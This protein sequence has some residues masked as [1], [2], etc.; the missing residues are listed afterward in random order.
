MVGAV[1]GGGGGPAAQLWVKN[2]LA[3]ESKETRTIDEE[4]GKAMGVSSATTERYKQGHVPSDK[5]RVKL[6][7]ERLVKP[8]HLNREWLHRF[9]DAAAY[10]K[11]EAL[12]KQFFP[13]YAAQERS[14]QRRPER[15]YHNLPVPTYAQ[16]INRP[17][18]FERVIDGI[19]QQTA[20]VMIA[21][22]GGSGKTSLAREVAACCL[23]G[24]NGAPKMEAAI[25]ISDKDR[26]GTTNLSMVL[27]EIARTLDYPGLAQ[28]AHS[29]KR[30][31]VE[32][33]V[34]TNRLLL[35]GMAPKAS[36]SQQGIITSREQHP[37]LW[38]SWPAL[39]GGLSLAEARAFIEQ[40]LRFL[41]LNPLAD[42]Q[43]QYKSL[44]RAT[45]GNPKAIE[46]A[47]G[48]LKYGHQPL[49]E[50][51]DNL[52]ATQGAL[53]ED[54]FARCWRL[55][56]T[57]AHRVLL[58]MLLFS[59]TAR[60]EALAVVA[61]VSGKAIGEVAA[62]LSNLALLDVERDDQNT[63]VSYSL[64]PL[65]RTFASAR[66][67]EW[68]TFECAARERWLRWYVEL[69]SDTDFA[70]IWNA[71]QR[72]TELDREHETVF[73]ATVWAS[74]HQR[75]E[76]V[77]KLA[78]GIEYYYYIRGLWEKRLETDRL[79]SAAARQL[80]NQFE[81]LKALVF[82]VQL[83]CRQDRLAEA[84]RALP[85]LDELTR[86]A[87]LPAA[88]FFYYQHARATYSMA[89]HDID[90]A[91]QAWQASLSHTRKHRDDIYAANIQWLATCRYL[92][93]DREEA[94]RLYQ[95]SLDLARDQRYQ[96]YIA[97]NQ[98]KLATIDLDDRDIA[99]AQE[100]LRE[101]R[102]VAVSSQDREHLARIQC[103]YG[104]LHA[105]RGN[106][107]AARKALAAAIDGFERLGLREELA[108]ARADVVSHGSSPPAC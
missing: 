51:V 34:R 78:K 99:G 33:L 13:E 21:G 90:A 47:L 19:Q 83:L 8:A 48:Y 75:Y 15:V 103:L 23:A 101:A 56:D 28:L 85:R 55:L 94:R 18:A 60:P 35:A 61:D 39:L 50:I 98:L 87:D 36:C 14:S 5:Q 100:R 71:P 74:A 53:F 24:S 106:I 107:P 65:V 66:L 86:A 41:G 32:Q 62:Q 54:L 89:Q 69:V 11:P 12:V 81:E 91:Q 26:P 45:G 38:G 72:L 57:E 1:F 46:V 63:V 2:T 3:D 68:E 77:L 30:Y 79:Y 80:G 67:A 10:P 16:F 93:G 105:M 43:T 27:D 64:H 84:E 73:A 96:H 7:A 22:L 6:L 17:E 52:F 97:L 95:E 37:R 44:I 76:A 88:A 104:R 108:E 82:H 58:A 42:N 40:R 31:E 9:L 92:Q 59:P 70:A 102:V 20:V 25:W 4:L 49:Q 29:E